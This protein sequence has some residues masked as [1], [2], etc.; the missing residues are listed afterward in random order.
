MGTYTDVKVCRVLGRKGRRRIKKGVQPL[1]QNGV[2]RL[3]FIL[4]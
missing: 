2:K 4:R 1:S 3:W